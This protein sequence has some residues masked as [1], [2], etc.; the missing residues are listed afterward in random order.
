LSEEAKLAYVQ[1]RIKET[2]RNEQIAIAFLLLGLIIA[3]VGFAFWWLGLYGTSG[4]WIGALGIILAIIEI[5]GYA[6]NRHIHSKL[7]R[8]FETMAK[9]LPTCP[10]CG[11][12]IPKS[13][14]KFC[15]F[16]GSQLTPSVRAKSRSGK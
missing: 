7:T 2:K 10:R 15:P 4:I 11:K 13:N 9:A 14:R 1:D 6:A 12:E 3:I 16:C 5:I 8:E